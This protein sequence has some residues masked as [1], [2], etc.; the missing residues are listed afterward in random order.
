MEREISQLVEMGATRAQ[1]KAAL[2]IHK[3]V[4]QAAEKIFEGKFDNVVDDDDGDVAMASGSGKNSPALV[5]SLCRL[6]R[7]ISDNI[8]QSPAVDSD[9]DVDFADGDEEDDDGASLYVSYWY[10]F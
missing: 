10:Y 7:S 3:D 6:D 9:E 4:M 2:A 8:P 5:S 1:A